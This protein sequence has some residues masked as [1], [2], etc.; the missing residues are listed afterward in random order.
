MVEEAE[1][2]G[3]GVTVKGDNFVGPPMLK[4]ANKILQKDRL[5]KERKDIKDFRDKTIKFPQ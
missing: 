5:I 4:M 3:K 1:A 2:E